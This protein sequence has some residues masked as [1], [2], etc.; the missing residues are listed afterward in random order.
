MTFGV[1]DELSFTRAIS[2]SAANA[3]APSF[4]FFIIYHERRSGPESIPTRAQCLLAW[5]LDLQSP[6]HD[7]M[8]LANFTTNDLDSCLK[9]ERL[10]LDPNN[11]LTSRVLKGSEFR[12]RGSVRFTSRGD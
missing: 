7:F 9:Q 12:V 11:K 5:F 4:V 3:I 6:I 10:V 8:P 1:A 2:L